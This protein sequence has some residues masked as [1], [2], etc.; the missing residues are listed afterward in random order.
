MLAPI[1]EFVLAEITLAL[2][3]KY[4]RALSKVL[5]FVNIFVELGLA[6]LDCKLLSVLLLEILLDSLSF[7]DLSAR[8]VLM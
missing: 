5:G 2:S 6:I 1:S 7:V 3:P 4:W 8:L